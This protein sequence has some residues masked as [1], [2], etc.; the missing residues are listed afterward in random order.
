MSLFVKRHEELEIFILQ[1]DHSLLDLIK[2]Y[3]RVLYGD[4]MFQYTYQPLIK[5]SKILKTS[6]KLYEVI[7]FSYVKVYIFIHWD[8]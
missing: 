8:K 5:D 1:F 7:F 2:I 3:L 4:H 6:K